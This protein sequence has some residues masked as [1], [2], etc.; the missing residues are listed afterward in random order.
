MLTKLF[1][2][3]TE[4]ATEL[5][6]AV[7][8]AEANLAKMS[9]CNSARPAKIKAWFDQL[10]VTDYGRTS[11]QM[12]EALLELGR[13]QISA[14]ARHEILEHIR[15]KVLNCVTSVA[16]PLIRKPLILPEAEK[17]SAVIA[18]ALLRHL[19]LG[20][21]ANVVACDAER[22]PNWAFI[23]SSCHRALTTLTAYLQTNYGFYTPVQDQIWR[24]INS[25]YRYCFSVEQQQKT[26]RDPIDPA[27]SG[28][29]EQSYLRCLALACSRPL[30]LR[31]KEIVL[32]NRELGRW[33]KMMK[34]EPFNP[35]SPKLFAVQTSLD[36]EP[37]Y[38][39]T[40][41]REQLPAHGFMFDFA[42]V[43]GNLEKSAS[44]GG[45]NE[46]P[47]NLRRHLLQHWGSRVQRRN[48]RQEKQYPVELCIGL[49]NIHA[50]LTKGAPFEEFVHGGVSEESLVFDTNWLTQ[51]NQQSDQGPANTST[52]ATVNNTGDTGFQLHFTAKVPS[53]LQAGELIGFREPGKRQWQLATV[54]WVK[55]SDKLGV[56]CGAQVLAQR[57][58]A[59]GGSTITAN[60]RDS[61]YLRVIVASQ[62]LDDPNPTIVTPS[63]V[64]SP[65][66]PI[67]L[68]KRG[69]NQSIQ[70][71][72]QMLASASFC[73]YRYKKLS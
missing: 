54:R 11:S 20:Y 45:E 40:F 67:T 64:F 49:I 38:L 13:L 37:D 2:R 39:D 69:E 63:S 56:Q 31:P 18:L 55:R 48:P 51:H 15:P 6:Q 30:Q 19:A 26:V 14:N 1:S 24:T 22:K 42:N 68:R 71:T 57:L 62:S 66:H 9:C 21:V 72:N 65:K 25:V 58:E 8:L 23:A 53:N 17:K 5:A 73:Q 29:C 32:I 50:L 70:I 34:L 7:G 35:D 10:P 27:L 47:V 12:Y 28:T 43:L 41:D 36:K 52:Q 59:Y 33:V 16:E 3:T 61:D 4:R 60:G 46:L 44:E